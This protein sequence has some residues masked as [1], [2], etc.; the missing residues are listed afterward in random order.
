MYN[1][2]LLL[3]LVLV[4]DLLA[5][6]L[7]QKRLTFK[8]VTGVVLGAI[9]IAVMA[10][11]LHLS[12]GLIFDTRSVVISMGT[13]FYGTLP[14]AIGGLIALTYR[15]ALGGSGS[16]MGMSVIAAAVIIGALWRRWRHIAERNPGVLEL[17]L[18]GLTVHIVMLAL[19]S[20]LPDPLATLRQIALAVIVIY[21]VASV[22][23]GLLMIDAR[24]RRRS[25]AALRESEQRFLAFIEQMP[26]RLWIRD[27]QLRYLYVNPELAADIGREPDDLLGKTP[28]EIWEPATAATARSLCERALGGERLDI[29]ERWPDEP[30]AGYYRSRVFA[31]SRDEEKPL[32]GGLMLDVTKQHMAEEELRRHAEQ[33]RETLEGAVLAIGHMVEARD[34]YTAGHQRRV[35]EL[36]TA[37]AERMRLS[38]G[39]IDGLRLACLVHDVGK[40]SVPAEILSKPGRLTETEFTLI[41]DHAASG[42]AI[43][44]DIEFERPLAE[45][46]LQHHERLDGSGYPRGLRGNEVSVEAKILAVAD[47]Y[48]AMVSHR[49]YRPALSPEEA[50]EEVRAGAGV[51]YDAE[52]VSCCLQLID[53]GFTFSDVQTA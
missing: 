35:T 17:Y 52:A 10:A 33:L 6:R 9:A 13:L 8:L 22:A 5:R 7:R 37:I 25:E 15:A 45:I 23:L 4:Y 27:H 30:G 48:E 40:I 46:V 24:R 49:P 39:E 36:A 20:T 2:A 11:A 31:I 3:V 43:L 32:L 12:N 21:P 14:G 42:H 41:Q 51:R 34:P 47:V 29:V 26:G 38:H 1:A 53:E 16:V 19:T 50:A 28:E 44:S 18:F